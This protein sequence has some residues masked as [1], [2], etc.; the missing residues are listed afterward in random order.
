MSEHEA[1]PLCVYYDGACP[2]CRREIDVYRRMTPH[3]PVEF[4]DVSGFAP[5][6]AVAPDLDGATAMRRFH[7]RDADGTLRDGADAFA[8]LW[9]RY[10]GFRFLG[11]ALRF[12][13]LRWLA[14]GAYR[15]FLVTVRPLIQ[16]A[17]CRAEARRNQAGGGSGDSRCTARQG[18][19]P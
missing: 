10:P 4:R 2:L 3:V 11:Q 12:P 6:E 16:R 14:E 13:P 17:V 18:T 7:V 15:I 8:A 19:G 9:R 1:A 5:E